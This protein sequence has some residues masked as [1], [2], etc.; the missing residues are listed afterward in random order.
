MGQSQNFPTQM[1]RLTLTTSLTLTTTISLTLSLT[2]TLRLTLSLTLDH[3][4]KLTG[5]LMQQRW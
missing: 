3:Y 4:F 2:Q 1:L 5:E